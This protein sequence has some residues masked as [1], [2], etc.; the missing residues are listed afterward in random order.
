MRVI[1][2]EKKG[3]SLKAV[4]GK[5][6]RPTTDKVKESI[7]NMIGPY[8]NGGDMLDLYGGS[9]AIAIE[10]LSR[11]MDRAV[12]IDRDKK[13]IETIYENV[14]K[15]DLKDKVEIFRTDAYRALYALKKKKRT[16]QFIFLD[17]PYKHHRLQEALTFIA[18][19]VLLKEDGIVVVEH[20]TEVKLVESYHTL[21]KIKEEKYGDTLITIYANKE[22]NNE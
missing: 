3:L 1:S 16:F 11:G 21:I 10:A 14:K 15:A 20:A 4:P 7:F 17:P 8:F 13:A 5:R 18:E 6:T 2:G 19:N 9:G 12:I 22:D